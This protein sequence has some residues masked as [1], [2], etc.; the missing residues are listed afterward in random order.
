MAAVHED[1]ELHARRPAA[2]EERLDR[3]ADRPPGVEDVVDQDDGR[4]FDVER[5]VGVP[6]DR[7]RDMRDDASPHRAPRR[8]RGRTRCRGCLTGSRGRRTR[9]AACGRGLPR[10]APRVW[11]P[12]TASFVAP[13]FFSRISCAMRVTVRPIWSRHQD[14]GLARGS[15]SR[16]RKDATGTGSRYGSVTHPLSVSQDAVKGRQ[17]L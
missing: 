6:D 15:G 8:R 7:L 16:H 12:T 4:A 13:G 3:G 1:R 11:I 2:V 9:R 17:R 14:D 5:Q 10:W